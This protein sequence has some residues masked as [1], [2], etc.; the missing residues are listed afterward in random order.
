MET[1]GQIGNQRSRHAPVV[2]TAM[3]VET[4]ILDRQQCILQDLRYVL[5]RYKIAVF[6]A[7]FAQQFTI[8]RVD[9]QGNLRS[10]IRHHIKRRQS[11]RT[12]ST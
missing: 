2:D 8:C 10:I 9:P 11:G 3:F 7:K 1:T 6:L 4:G 5:Y 12:V